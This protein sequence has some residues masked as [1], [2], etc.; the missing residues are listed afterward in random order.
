MKH[1]NETHGHTKDDGQTTEYSIWCAM[2]A[3]CHRV[4][5]SGY[6][7]YGAKG[8][9]VCDR[10]RHSFEDFLVDMGPRPGPEYSI[11]RFPDCNGNYEP[12]N[13]R[14]ATLLE[15]ANNKTTNRLIELDG[16]TKTLAQW[17]RASGIDADVIALRID[18]HG[19]EA[20]EAIFTPVRRAT[21][22]LKGIYYQAARRKWNVRFTSNAVLYD[23]GRFETLLDAA[24]ALLGNTSRNAREG[25]KQ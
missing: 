8:I 9:S 17:A 1:F 24:S 13:C 21:S 11:D 20:R 15:Q 23:L 16:A 7:K 2:K 3:R 12:G 4:G 5:S 6:E 10:W 14:W 22:G 25:V 18:K 19:W